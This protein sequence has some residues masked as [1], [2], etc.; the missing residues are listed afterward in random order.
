MASHHVMKGCTTVPA[1]GKIGLENGDLIEQIKR[2]KIA[3]VLHGFIGPFHQLICCWAVGQ[4][5]F[6]PDLV[7][8]ATCR[9]GVGYTF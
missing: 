9:L 2:D 6:F 4:A 7:G 5:P 8:Y 1:F 3:V